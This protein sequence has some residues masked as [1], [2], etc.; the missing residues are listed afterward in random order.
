M[1]T[2]EAVKIDAYVPERWWH[3]LLRVLI[4]GSTCVVFGIAGL[5]FMYDSA[6]YS[7]SYAYSFEP[8]Y[9]QA[10]GEEKICYYYEETDSI[11]C[12]G[13]NT[14]RDLTNQIKAIAGEVPEDISAARPKESS[15]RE[16]LREI[17][18]AQQIINDLKDEKIR[19][20]R[21]SHL[22]TGTLA[23]SIGI[24]L[25]ISTLWYLFALLLYKVTLY[26]AYGHT[27]IVKA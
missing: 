7:Y 14:L 20:R 6:N 22:E 3:R 12:G 9:K 13:L 1:T 17:D 27:R 25:G 2:E 4:Y 10:E 8:N 21:I 5:I 15:L 19:Y 16:A 11:H 18:A 23:K 26:I 24:T